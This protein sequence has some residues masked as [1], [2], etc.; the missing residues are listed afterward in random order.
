MFVCFNVIVVSSSSINSRSSS[1]NSIYLKVDGIIKFCH[2]Q[3]VDVMAYIYQRIKQR[4]N[5][6]KNKSETQ[7]QDAVYE[8]NYGTNSN[9]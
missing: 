7:D 6:I 1:S 5:K 8:Q 4:N 9:V 3:G 2:D